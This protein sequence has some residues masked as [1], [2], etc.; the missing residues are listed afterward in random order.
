MMR[1]PPSALHRACHLPWRG[2][3][4]AAVLLASCA[5]APWPVPYLKEAEGT[6]T[7]EQV[8]QRLG[9]PPVTLPLPE[10][11]ALWTY[12]YTRGEVRVGPFECWDYKLTFDEQQVLRHWRRQPCRLAVRGYD[13]ESDKEQF[14]KPTDR[15]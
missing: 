15:P 10:G 3:W 4:T 12:R 7:Q 6:A 9:Q 13:P 8:T 14:L 11:G 2:L 1:R 5:P